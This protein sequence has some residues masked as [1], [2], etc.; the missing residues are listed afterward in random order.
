[1][2]SREN[3]AD[4]TMLA[5]TKSRKAGYL[6]AL[7]L[8]VTVPYFAIEH[9]LL[10]T[11]A[12]VPLT[13]IDRMLPFFPLAI[14]WFVS[15]YLLLLLPLLLVRDSVNLRQ[16]AFGFGWIALASHVVFVLWPTAIPALVSASQVADPMLRIVLA[17]DTNG[18][19]M[20]S[21]HA[22]LAVYCALCCTR[23]VRNWKFRAALWVWVLLILVSTLLAKRHAFL[24]ICAGSA[25]GWGVFAALF[26][27]RREESP[28]CEALQATLRAR[29]DMSRGFEVEVE[30]LAAQDWRKRALE[31]A[32]FIALA[33]WGVW[34]T[35]TSW[36][37][38]RWFLLAA[39][40]PVTALALNAFVLL[41]HDGMH[42]SLF[43]NRRWNRIGSVLLGATFFMS[44]SAYRVLHAR[45][46][47]FLGDSRDPDD[48]RNYLPRPRVLLW[49]LHF[50]RLSVGPLLYLAL[51]PVLALKHGTGEERRHILAEYLFLLAAY[52]VL[53]R[54]V[55]G[56]L[57]LIAWLVPLLM[58]AAFTA[59]RGFTQHGITD[60]S[61]PYI[62]SR[63][64]LP[65]PL[66]GFF[67]LHENYHL[68]HHLFPEVPSYHLPR[69]HRL[70]WP[71]LPRVVSGRS[72]LGFLARF[73]RA[74]PRLDETPIG[75]QSPAEKST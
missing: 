24:D 27:T 51:I 25:L 64:I 39:G 29:E 32:V 31:F 19:A 55:P 71:R 3:T 48:Y 8:L 46:H 34:L 28:E 4:T 57:L 54:F 38:S 66:V 37:N 53:L 50:M 41:M 18:N 72:Y 65:N 40:I 22:S 49:S 44:Y 47:R 73:L 43:P 61:D 30:R 16:M 7:G 42:S 60:A 69:L 23:L 35:A 20:P 26:R 56:A 11:P 9:H 74:T 63:T 59:I 15:L 33:V 13:S 10:F 62:A 12:L 68:E 45:H 75:L 1:M 17:A 70:I 58:V 21:L 14:W 52:S 67:L 6:L 36:T 2:K 5:S